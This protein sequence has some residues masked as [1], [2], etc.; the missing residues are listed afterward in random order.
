M[1]PASVKPANPYGRGKEIIAMN[2]WFPDALSITFGGKRRPRVVLVE[3]S[4]ADTMS[5]FC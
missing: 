3:K 1:V 5:G 4:C 2:E